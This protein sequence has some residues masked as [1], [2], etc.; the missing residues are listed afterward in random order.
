MPGPVAS[1]HEFAVGAVVAH[2]LVE[3]G[4][5]G[6]SGFGGA[7]GFGFVGRIECDV[8]PHAHVKLAILEAR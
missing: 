5:T 1:A 2:D 3:L 8:H 7:L 4:E 6:K